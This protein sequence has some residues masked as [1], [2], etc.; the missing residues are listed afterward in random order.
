MDHIVYTQALILCHKCFLNDYSNISENTFAIQILHNALNSPYNAYS[1]AKTDS[2]NYQRV[3]E[4]TVHAT[5]ANAELVR[6]EAHGWL[7]DLFKLISEKE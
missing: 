7:Q 5:I 2:F 6:P 1:F 3:I 4:K